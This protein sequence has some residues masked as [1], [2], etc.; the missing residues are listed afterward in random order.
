[1]DDIAAIAAHRHTIE[2]LIPLLNAIRSVAEIAWR[3]AEQGL[4]PLTRYSEQTQTV[5]ETVVASLAADRRTSITAGWSDARTALLLVTS[6][7]GLCGPFNDR[8]ISG[9]LKLARELTEQG[10]VVNFI[11]LGSRGQRLLEAR[12]N[13]SIYSR[14][15][16]SFS[17]PTYVDIE[18]VALDMLD[19]L[20]QQV[21]GR[22]VVVHNTPVQR[23]QY[24]LITNVLLPPDIAIPKGHPSSVTVKP[25]ADAPALLTH[26]LT[27]HLLLGL[28]RAVL[29][30]AISEQ[31][32]RIYT[33]RLAVEHAEK[34]LETLTLDYNLARRHDET[35]SLL[36][37]VTGY[38]ATLDSSPWQRH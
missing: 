31:L 13:T 36:E 4:Y 33:M 8:V 7:R 21:F 18:E 29:E 37:I 3:R 26:L 15:L 25:V 5:L 20:E 28:Y 6:E 32:A 30:S 11:C 24:G 38:E 14:T 35:T 10:K 19:L 2:R 34:L 9:G 22:L 23:F 16:P 17:V 27:E 1:M 12:G